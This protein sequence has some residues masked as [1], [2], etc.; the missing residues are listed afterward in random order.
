MQ[1]EQVEVFPIRK[2]SRIIFLSNRLT[3]F[4]RI[5]NGTLKIPKLALL[6]HESERNRYSQL[7]DRVVYA[8][9]FHNCTLSTVQ[10]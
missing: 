9:K 5:L 7:V 4:F 2:S 10:D 6:I 1:L 3:R 8:D